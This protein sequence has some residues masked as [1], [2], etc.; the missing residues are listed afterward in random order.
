ML[1][2]SI[3]LK[4]VLQ[5]IWFKKKI[6][7]PTVLLLSE[8]THSSSTSLWFKITRVCIFTLLQAKY[9]RLWKIFIDK[10][11]RRP[12]C[13]Y[14]S[15]KKKKKLEATN[16]PCCL[17]ELIFD[18]LVVTFWAKTSCRAEIS[19]TFCRIWW[20]ER[21]DIVEEL[22]LL[23]GSASSFFY[24][25]HNI[26]TLQERNIQQNVATRDPE[27]TGFHV[28]MRLK[29]WITQVHRHFSNSLRAVHDAHAWDVVLDVHMLK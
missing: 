23:S 6:S 10:A 7:K 12:P 27:E 1:E 25:R 24:K 16:V 3:Y 5:N 22:V 18:E 13:V 21:Q 26:S 20:H 11:C 15:M 19:R 14:T 28:L 8:G 2:A 9:E 17:K 4:A 29:K